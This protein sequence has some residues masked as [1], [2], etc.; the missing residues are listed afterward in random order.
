MAAILQPG[1]LRWDGTKYVLDQDVEI[2][3]PAG[4]AGPTGGSGP[5][6]VPGIGV[7]AT[8]VGDLTGTYPNPISVVGLTGV[9]GVVTFGSAIN[10][11]TITQTSISTGNGKP[12][13]LRA[14]NTASGVGGNVNL[15]SG[16]GTTAG[17]VQ[18]LVGN[19]IAGYFD[20]NSI[21]R[22]SSNST[23]TIS[24]L[25]A[26]APTANVT[27]LYSYTSSVNNQ[28]VVATGS[29]A[30]QA[31]MDFISTNITPS[32]GRIV[33]SGPTDA[34][35][36]WASNFVIE[37]VGTATSS[38]LFSKSNNVGGSRG[39]LGRLYQTGALALGDSSTNNTS[40]LAQAGLTGPVISLA[41]AAGTM[42]STAG[43]ALL[44]NQSGSAHLQGATDVRFDVAANL[45]GYFDSNRLLRIGPSATSSLTILNGASL[46]GVNNYL[47]SYNASGPSASGF[48]SGSTSSS[49]V[50]EVLNTNG[51]GNT[52]SGL[53]IIS[54]GT[55]N[56]SSPTEAGNGSINQIGSATSS[57]VFTSLGGDN[58]NYLINGRFYRSGAW[59]IGDNATNNTSTLAQA[60]LTGYL[61]NISPTSGGSMTTTTNQALLFNTAGTMS[62]QG[63]VAVNLIAGTTSVASVVPTKFVTNVGRRVKV[64]NITSGPYTVLTTD[65]IISVG[66]LSATLTITLP[67]SPTTGDTY[68][69]KDAN[70]SA[71]AFNITVQGNGNNIDVGATFVLTANYSSITVVY[72]GSKWIIV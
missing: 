25:G 71:A 70:G 18:F 61:L 46:P 24:W 38:L 31:T 23:G 55:G 33:A 22:I 67:S 49:A 45:A 26:T 42:T 16:T 15:Q 20:A 27:S 68:N 58:T 37:Q 8:A 36:G 54:A 63:N 40:T 43:Q 5:Q 65:D 41:S 13:T 32:G 19:N 48:Y 51:A 11:P 21:L 29:S 7:G 14:Q 72:N 69:I 53:R 66:T 28:M 3:G 62:V 57:L 50:M 30:G 34:T 39:T 59:T 2:V 56:G 64:T 60:G 1:Y 9:S 17:L 6:G 12:M 52:T 35:S 47:F 4:I 44:F 10:N